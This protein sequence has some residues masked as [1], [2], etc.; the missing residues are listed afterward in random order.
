M[1]TQTHSLAG[2]LDAAR[3]SGSRALAIA[4]ALGV[5]VSGKEDPLPDPIVYLPH[6]QNPAWIGAGA[7]I[8]RGRGDL[9]P[10]TAALRKEVFA[11]DPDLPLRELP[12]ASR[13]RGGW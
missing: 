13:P 9:G 5:H 8:V 1:L 10:L 11:L 6:D 4:H 7:M 3:V 12:A 2:D